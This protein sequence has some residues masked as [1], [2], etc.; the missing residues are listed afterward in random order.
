MKLKMNNQI[1]TIERALE[2][3]VKRLAACEITQAALLLKL[4]QRGCPT[5]I[6]Q[7][8]VGMMLEKGYLNDKRSGERLL[9][10][11]RRNGK[12]GVGKLKITLRAQ[13]V[14]DALQQELLATVTDEEELQYA[15]GAFAI[16]HLKQDDPRW[17]EKALAYLVRRGFTLATAQKIV[18]ESLS[19]PPFDLS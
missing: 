8:A 17:K 1:L 12:N 7:Q 11:W 14:D 4:K 3:C 13:G 19:V 15:R 5:E 9:R 6:A 16:Y 10:M 2:Y 18:P